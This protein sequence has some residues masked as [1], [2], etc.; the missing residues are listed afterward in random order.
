M[1]RRKRKSIVACRAHLLDCAIKFACRHLCDADATHIFIAIYSDNI[2]G[3]KRCI[4]KCAVSQ[5]L[6]GNASLQII[7]FYKSAAQHDSRKHSDKRHHKYRKANPSLLR[8]FVA[9]SDR[10]GTA[11][12]GYDY[13]YNNRQHHRSSM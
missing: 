2:A 5:P 9:F 10:G 1:H 11:R 8:K 13:K 3:K 6:D 12:Y 4:I 7:P